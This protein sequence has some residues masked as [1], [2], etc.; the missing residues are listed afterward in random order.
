MSGNELKKSSNHFEPF[1]ALEVLRMILDIQFNFREKTFYYYVVYNII[2]V[3]VLKMEES[4]NT[5]EQKR[6]D[7]NCYLKQ[8]QDLR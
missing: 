2:I 1:M 7:C 6:E 8:K 3:I 4:G 5:S